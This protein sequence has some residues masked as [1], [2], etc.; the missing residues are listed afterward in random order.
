MKIAR[1]LYIYFLKVI[2]SGITRLEISLCD[3]HLLSCHKIFFQTGLKICI[4]L[5]IQCLSRDTWQG[6][7]G[8]SQ[9][10]ILHESIERTRALKDR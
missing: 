6:R 9:K 2:T 5:Q 1:R 7:I 3:V 4:K 8:M 10:I